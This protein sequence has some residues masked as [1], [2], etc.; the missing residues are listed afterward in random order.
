M[1]S[2]T[3]WDFSQTNKQKKNTA[4]LMC[5]IHQLYEKNWFPDVEV[6]N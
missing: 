5:G 2:K 3:A 1:S 6:L 4:N